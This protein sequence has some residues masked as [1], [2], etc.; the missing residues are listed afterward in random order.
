M[1]SNLQ[2]L[3]NEH[4]TAPWNCDYHININ[5]QMNYWP[6][7]VCNLSEC[8]EPFFD[9]IDNLRPRGRVTARELYGCRGFTA[10]HTT[11][12]WWWTA[13]IGKTGYGMWP[14]GAAWCCQHLWERYL[15]TGDEEFLRD[16]GYPAM[17]EAAEFCLDL[18]TED[19]ETGKLVSGPS[20]SPENR[21]RTPD[22]QSAQLSM[23]CAMDQEIIWDL[24]SSCVEAAKVLGIEDEFTARAAAALDKLSWPKIGSDGRLME[25][26]EEFEEP[27]PGHRHVSHLFGLHPGRQFTLRTTPELVAAAQKSLE[28]RLANGGGHTG[29]SRAWIIN[30]WARLL[31]PEKAQE[32]IQALLAK[33]THPNLFDNHPP[34]QIDGNYGGTA[35]VAEMLVQSHEGEIALLPCLPREAWPTGR[36][37]GLRARGGVE[38]DI[39]WQ[40]GVA[41]AAELRPS[42]TGQILLRAPTGQQIDKITCE[43]KP[44][45]MDESE[46]GTVA[47]RLDAGKVYALQFARGKNQAQRKPEVIP[48]DLF[49]EKATHEEG[50]PLP[51][52]FKKL[53]AMRF[54]KD[55]WLLTCDSE[56]KQI[57]A[58]EAEGQVTETFELPFGPESIDVAANGTIYCGGQGKLAKLDAEGRVLK[59]ADVPS[60]AG[61][62]V[63]KTARKRAAASKVAVKL[64]VSGIAVTERDV[65]IAFGTGWSTVS[66]SRLFRLDRELE[67]PQM[68][69]GKLRGCCQRCDLVALGDDVLVAENSA[70]RVVRYDRDGKVLNKWGEKSR[71]GLE[72][73][74]ACCNPMNVCFDAAGRLYTAESGLGRIKTY[75]ID[76]ELIDLVGYVDTQRFRRGSAMASSC[77]NMAL[78]ASPD[79]ERVYVMDYQ[80]N[81]IR[82]LQRKA[83]LEV[84]GE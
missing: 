71:T 58:I 54:H 77:S 48:P 67:N 40:D 4:I 28:H 84:A 65:Y 72:G 68:L 18:L 11:D 66:L 41:T 73:F 69:A 10:H 30:F 9:L 56:L 44:V 61:E 8:H 38:L 52:E 46:A 36:A 2:G 75:S 79:G 47:V 37:T 39:H 53:T 33:S 14:L 60:D 82:V 51:V 45:S 6:A 7:E 13:A 43:S 23:G 22:G 55:G 19:P 76:G 25:W 32:N 59:L 57:I 27:S 15:F 16:R 83:P 63:S 50:E 21:F 70:F 29:W 78:A 64:R 24:L 35:A 26:A 20:T 80:N 1:P 34:F 49:P 31:E 3:W 62:P 5:I 81:K 42:L 17:K 12:A 74:G